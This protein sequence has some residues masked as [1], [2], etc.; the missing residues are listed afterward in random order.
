MRVCV[1]C[2]S[3][4]GDDPV[5]A[6]ATRRLGTLLA[7]RGHGL[8]YGGGHI[9]L[10][11]VVA[12]AVLAAGGEA[13]GVIPHHL[14]QLEVAHPGLTQL[15]V[16]DSMHTRKALMADLADAFIAAPGGFGTLDE[17]CEIL[18]WAQLGLH[19]KPAGLLNVAGYFDPLLAMFDQAVSAGFLSPAHRALILSDD[20]PARLLD[21]LAADLITGV[22][23]A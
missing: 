10:M 8:V 2:G 17:L 3:R 19:R 13:I 6:D 14:Q 22:P 20:D 1:F 9:G 12:D 5:H 11:G 4:S 15:H 7:S 21:R 23:A 16:V 18:T